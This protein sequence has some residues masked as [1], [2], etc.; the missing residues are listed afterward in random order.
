M[1]LTHLDAYAVARFLAG[2]DWEHCL[3]SPWL[4]NIMRNVQSSKDKRKVLAEL[5][6]TE[7][8]AQVFAIDPRGDPPQAKKE[9]EPVHVPDLPSEAQLTDADKQAA[10]NAAPF[11]D[12]FLSWAKQRSPMTPAFYLESAALYAIAVAAA[13][14]C[15]INLHGPIAPNL[16]ILWVAPTSIFKKTTGM[17]AVAE[18]IDQAIAHM[19]LPTEMTPESFITNLAGKL[20]PNYEQLPARRRKKIDQ[21]RLFAAQRGLL[22]DEAS[23]MLG[24]KKKDYMQ[25][26][27]ELLMRGFDSSSVPYCRQTISE[28]HLEI[29]NLS[30]CILGA[31]TPAAFSRNTCYASWET[32]Q[33][34]R[35]ALLFPSACLPYQLPELNPEDYRPPVALVQRLVKLHNALPAPKDQ[36]SLNPDE[37]SGL[38][39]I[40]ASISPEAWSHYA[41]YAKVMT[42]DLLQEDG[43]DERLK[44]NYARLAD[45]AAKVALN[46]ALINW[47]DQGAQGAPHIGMAEW[48]RGQLVAE[49][50]RASAH[51]LLKAVDNGDDTRNENR[52]LDHLHRHPAGATL[53]E[54]THDLGLPRKTIQEA[55]DALRSSG[56]VL[57][58]KRKPSRG[59]EATIYVSL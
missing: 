35:Y 7:I 20:P 5:L 28:G 39:P 31:T 9:V 18:L 22:I 58:Q 4:A 41:S 38:E 2:L 25:G 37:P 14:R 21:G 57:E 30:L 45:A 17:T 50:W 54:I 23:S 43:L 44:G 53:R 26:M 11:V 36:L 55:L 34:A 6:G 15:V 27:E 52:I 3:A 49:S 1:N 48:A 32:G 29:Q 51:R 47:A 40:S 8:A 16:Y 59:P 42:Y 24:A 19:I 46:L 13:K 10:E 56:D 12:E 33:L